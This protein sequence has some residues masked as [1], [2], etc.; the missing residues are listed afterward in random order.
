MASLEIEL[1]T[2]Q[3]VASGENVMHSSEPPI[4]QH[5]FEFS[6][7]PVDRGKDAWLF[8]AAAF[9]VEALVWGFPFSFGVFQDYYSTHPPFAGSR[10]IAVIGT[11]AMGIMYLDLPIIF[12]VMQRWPKTRPFCTAAGLLVMC[13]ALSLSSF[14]TTATHLMVT[15]GVIYAVGGSMAYAPCII[16]MD[17]WF[18]KRKGLA[19]GIMWASCSTPILPAAFSTNTMSRL[20]QDWPA[21]FFRSSCSTSSKNMA[22]RQPFAHGL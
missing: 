14:S 8:L 16:Y 1:S 21:S 4:E 3:P 7:P 12:A 15:Q 5:E 22:T 2:I 13:L 10:N 18:V 9:I 20:E 11:C 19:F 6:L 17:E